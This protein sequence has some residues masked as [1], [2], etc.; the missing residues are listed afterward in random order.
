MNTAVVGTTTVNVT[1]T[2]GIVL[3]AGRKYHHHRQTTP[4]SDVAKTT[5]DRNRGGE[6][7]ERRIQRNVY[8]LTRINATISTTT[9][10]TVERSGVI[11]PGALT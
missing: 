6:E 9:T 2:N 5:S 4:P 10:T 3:S 11:T 7:K 1:M 8:D